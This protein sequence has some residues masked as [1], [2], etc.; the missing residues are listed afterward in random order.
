MSLTDSPLTGL[1]GGDVDRGVVGRDRVFPRHPVDG[2]HLKAVAGVSLQ[3]PHHHL[4][5]PQPQ[6]ARRDVHVVIA[7]RA[8]APVAEALLTHHIVDKIATP[9]CVV[10][11]L[12]LQGQ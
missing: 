5:R 3:V 12:P 2:L 9:T 10:R 1:V 7:A 4:S 8:R 6:L 11:L